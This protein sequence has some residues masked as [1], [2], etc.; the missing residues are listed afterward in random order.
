MDLPT[1]G[2]IAIPAA[3]DARNELAHVG[4]RYV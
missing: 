1:P 2:S 4:L 3:H